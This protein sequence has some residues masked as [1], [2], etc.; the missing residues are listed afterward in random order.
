M[1]ESINELIARL[2]HDGVVGGG[3]ADVTGDDIEALVIEIER[4]R[5]LLDIDDSVVDAA[6]TFRIKCLRGRA[7]RI[8]PIVKPILPMTIDEEGNL[9]Y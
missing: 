5:G 7:P 9:S 8:L 2:R 6:R 3:Y 4:L 1:S